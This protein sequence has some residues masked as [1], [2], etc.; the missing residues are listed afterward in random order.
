[1]SYLSSMLSWS[2]LTAPALMDVEVAKNESESINID[3]DWVEVENENEN[4]I[5]VMD[6][7]DG[8]GEIELPSYEEAVF[9]D[10]KAEVFEF[11][12]GGGFALVPPHLMLTYTKV[13]QFELWVEYADKFGMSIMMTVN[14]EE[15]ASAK[16][17]NDFYHGVGNHV[18]RF[19]RI[20]ISL[21]DLS[22]NH[23]EE[24]LKCLRLERTARIFVTN[25]FYD[26]V[27]DRS[28]R[29][30][31][32]KINHRIRLLEELCTRRSIEEFETMGM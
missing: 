14:P 2:G 32:E 20:G 29:L 31:M 28:H 7:T 23:V 17:G 22:N 25:E 19:F 12:L 8:N 9:E 30:W 21:G 16:D 24:M 13:Q 1:M 18:H 11:W 4:E 3:D 6:A 27:M 26:G 10:F 5:E 15:I